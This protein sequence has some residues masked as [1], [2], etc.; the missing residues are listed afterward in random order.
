MAQYIFTSSALV[1]SI[2]RI[3]T[4]K[5][6]AL[7]LLLTTWKS[8]EKEATHKDNIEVCGKGSNTQRQSDTI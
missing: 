3:D 8:A 2:K 6:V 7:R 1:G 5:R 4:I